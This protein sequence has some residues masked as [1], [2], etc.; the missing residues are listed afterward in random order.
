MEKN[1][2]NLCQKLSLCCASN[3][4]HICKTNNIEMKTVSRQIK[5]DLQVNLE[6]NKIYEAIKTQKTTVSEQVNIVAEF[7]NHLSKAVAKLKI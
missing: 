1:E 4:L 6:F 5:T 7:Q 3:Y 2:T